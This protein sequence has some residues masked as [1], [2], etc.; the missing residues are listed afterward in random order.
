MVDIVKVNDVELAY[1]SFGSQADEAVILVAGLGYM[2]LDMT[3][4][5]QKTGNTIKKPAAAFAAGL[6]VCHET[7]T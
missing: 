6:E 7:P 1:D 2:V 3:I 5:E 4:M